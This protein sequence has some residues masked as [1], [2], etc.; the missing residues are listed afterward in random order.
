LFAF[1]NW[2]GNLAETRIM[3]LD[4]RWELFM[5]S[6]QMIS[7]SAFY[8]NFDKPIEIVR[9]PEQQTSTEFQPRNVGDGQLAGVEFEFRKRLNFISPRLHAF[10]L[11]G[12]ITLVSSKIDMTLTEFN[13]RKNYEKA[14]ETIE[15]TRPMAGQSPFVI[16]AGLTYNHPE[17]GI[18]AGIF[19]NVKGETLYIVGAGLFPDI[20]T[21]PFHSVNVSI[22]RSFG[23]N[24]R[25]SIDFRVANLLNDRV[26]TFYQSF[27]AEN[28]IFNSI[29]PNRTFSLGCSVKF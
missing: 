19:Y 11:N 27:R 18:N 14:G 8:K 1:S 21:E 13:S 29:N 9:I 3:N 4:L 24:D 10:A 7:V 5:N 2:D 6:N 17:N 23:K 12:N 26:E 15:N 20:Y 16:N 25:T 28:Q 22:S